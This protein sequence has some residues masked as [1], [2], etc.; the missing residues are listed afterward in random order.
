MQLLCNADKNNYKSRLS[1]HIFAQLNKSIVTNL[2]FEMQTQTDNFI[3]L[4]ISGGIG[5]NILATAVVKAIKRENPEM[6]IVILTAWKD[7]WLYNPSIYRCYKFDNA[8]Y[9]FSNYVNGKN[10]KVFALEPYQT[11]GYILKKEHLL[12]SWCTLCGVEYK[13][14]TPELFFNQREIEYVVNNVSKNDPILLVQTH[15]GG[16]ADIKHSWMR[17]LPINIAQEVVNQFRGE[18]RIIHVRR[19]DQLP[20]QD[21]EQFKG[22]IRELMVLVRESKYRLFIDSMCQHTAMALGKKSTVCWIRNY[23]HVLGY[24]F[25]DNYLCDAQDEIDALDFSLLEPYDIAGHIVQCPFKE[26]TKLF[27]V[28]ILVNSIRNQA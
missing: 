27:D 5:K 16:N 13:G 24:D 4:S 28:Q 10:V 21:V 22:G 14:E 3:V 1:E 18:A 12:V 11:E 23:P 2:D 15:G 17:D 7:A 25:H 6:N 8:P 20:L 19:D 26:G 9:F